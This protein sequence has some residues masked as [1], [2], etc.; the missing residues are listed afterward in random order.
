MAST[1]E[2]VRD[3]LDP[4]TAA[5]AVYEIMLLWHEANEHVVRAESEL[6]RNNNS[7]RKM[8]AKRMAYEECLAL[9][10]GTDR[11]GVQALLRNHYGSG[12]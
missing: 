11:V 1:I 9:F 10:L 12:A 8:R 4:Q 7:Y 5:N 6:G 2:R 3:S